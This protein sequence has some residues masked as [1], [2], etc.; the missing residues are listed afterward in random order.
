MRILMVLREHDAVLTVVVNMD[1][2][3]R[4]HELFN[5]K[6]IEQ[7]N[8][9]IEQVVHNH[10]ELEQWT[11]SDIN[12]GIIRSVL[13]QIALLRKTQDEDDRTADELLDREVR[14]A[15]LIIRAAEAPSSAEIARG[16]I[17]RLKVSKQSKKIV[18]K[19]AKSYLAK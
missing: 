13:D 4:L 17:D 7:L 14:K 15:Q 8:K 3:M 19:L 18:G 6:S 2:T 5:N 16:R 11:A 12:G 10:N 9:S 1:N